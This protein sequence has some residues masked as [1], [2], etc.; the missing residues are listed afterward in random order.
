MKKAGYAVLAV[1]LLIMAVGGYVLYH[2]WRHEVFEPPTY[3]TTPPEL[4]EMAEGPRVLVFS[5]TN[6][7]RHVDA[8]PAANAMFRDFAEAEGWA[9]FFTENGAVH[10]SGDLGRFDVLVWNNVS[11]DVLTEAQ[12]RAF[13]EYLEGGGAVLGIH[14]TGGSPQYDWDWYP[15]DFICAQ[16]TGHPVLPQFQQAEVI[17]ETPAHPAMAHLPETWTFTDEWYSFEE[18]PRDRVEVLASL[19]E[20]TYT[21]ALAGPIGDLRMGDHPIIWH[22]TVGEGHVFYSA[23]GHRAAAYRNENYRTLLREACLWLLKQRTTTDGEA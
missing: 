13:K 2:Q 18:S 17:V 19:D 6:S 5:K 14:A 20:D 21:P 15:R 9:V 22:H 23:L 11:G 16:F 1:A 8:I 3:E 10:K 4:P 12:R 7:F